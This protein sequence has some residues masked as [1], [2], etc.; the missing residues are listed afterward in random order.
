MECPEA[1]SGDALE[2]ASTEEHA[3]AH[4]GEAIEKLL[5]DEVFK[6]A[7]GAEMVDQ[8]A[9]V[10]TVEWE[11]YLNANSSW[12]ESLDRFTDWEA[13]YYLPYL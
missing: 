12:E 10:K 13:S 8:F 9:A 2:V 5:Q 11:K 7:I 3:P 4:L 1:E 6:N